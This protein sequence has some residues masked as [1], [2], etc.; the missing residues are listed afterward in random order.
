M[1]VFLKSNMSPGCLIWET[2]IHGVFL[3][4]NQLLCDSSIM[5]SFET[6]STVDYNRNECIQIQFPFSPPRNNLGHWAEHEVIHFAGIK[7]HEFS[8]NLF[9][10]HV[11]GA[12][13][14]L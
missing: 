9:S 6:P 3:C 8:N 4:K 11:G 14:Q 5:P 7:E 12:T 2:E 10:L 1:F 13:K